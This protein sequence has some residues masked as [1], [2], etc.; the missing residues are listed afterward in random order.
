MPYGGYNTLYIY[1]SDAG[2][3]NYGQIYRMEHISILPR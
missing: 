2:K 3:A 1:Y